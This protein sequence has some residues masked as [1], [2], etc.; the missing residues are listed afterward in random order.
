MDARTDASAAGAGHRQLVLTRTIDA[1]PEI[2][3][4]VWSKPEHLAQWWGPSGFSLPSCDLDFRPGGTFRYQMRS[5]SGDEWLRG[6]FR[7]IVAPRR[8]V[9]TFAWGDAERAT[10]PETLVEVTFESHVGKTKLTLR[11]SGFDTESATRGHEG[12]W[13]QSLDRL[14]AYAASLGSPE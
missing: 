3:F 2:V 7:E 11:H 8:I 9:F 5:A 6:V 13:S 12:G 4:E 14:V 1:P 10:H